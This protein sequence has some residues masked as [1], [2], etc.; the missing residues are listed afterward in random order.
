MKYCANCGTSANDFENNC[1]QCGAPLPQAAPGNPQGK[2]QS[3]DIKGIINKIPKLYLLIAV[4]AVALLVVIVVISSIFSSSYED[5]LNNY[6][7]VFFY[8]KYN[9]IE[10]LAPKEF[11]DYAKDEEDI[12][13]KDLIENLKENEIAEEWIEEY[14]DDYGK[15]IK[16][17]FKVTDKD[18]LKKSDLNDIKDELKEEYDIPKKSV[19]KG[20]ELEIEMKIK[21]KED[22]DEDDAEFTVIQIDG[23]W[24][25]YEEGMF[26][27]AFLALMAYEED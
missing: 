6:F 20:Y 5:A 2:K 27:G 11:W 16:V 4:A 12:K 26:P 14:E 17:S 25:I 18:E 22:S 1:P 9:K 24:Y 19:T 3:F 23:D 15:N 10:K 7:D 8:G 13:I 21:G